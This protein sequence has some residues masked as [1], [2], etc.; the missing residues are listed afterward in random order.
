MIAGET[1]SSCRLAAPTGPPACQTLGS[2]SN[3]FTAPPIIFTM[4]FGPRANEGEWW[5]IV[6]A[7]LRTTPGPVVGAMAIF[8]GAVLTSCFGLVAGSGGEFV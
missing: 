2:L 4:R 3:I 7:I 8:S 1:D 6:Q 5:Q